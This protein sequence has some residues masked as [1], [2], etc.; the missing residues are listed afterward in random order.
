[1]LFRSEG[2]AWV[3][4]AVAISIIRLVERLKCSLSR[5]FPALIQFAVHVAGKL[6]GN[7]EPGSKLKVPRGPTAENRSIPKV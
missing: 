7:S 4:V 2:V 5:A 3:S 6:V 1:M